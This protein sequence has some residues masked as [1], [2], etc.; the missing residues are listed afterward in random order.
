MANEYISLA[1]FKAEYDLVNTSDDTELAGIL[2]SG[3]RLVDS[4]CLRY[5]YVTQ[6][7]RKFDQDPFTPFYLNIID[8][9]FSLTSVVNGDGSTIPLAKIIVYPLRRTP[10][11]P[12]GWLE[13]AA[14][15]RFVSDG[16]GGRQCLLVDGKW[17]YCDGEAR[18]EAIKRATLQ[19]SHWLYKHPDAIAKVAGPTKV[20][21]EEIV[22]MIP[23]AVLVILDP[24]I[25]EWHGAHDR[26]R[27]SQQLWPR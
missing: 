16:L 19:L 9:L 13:L 12:I 10:S 2:T 4:I 11:I 15:E 20:G 17:G 8:D 3:S 27:Q 23:S 24:Y 14:G 18:P 22:T 6:E 7:V 25:R 5:F 21:A 1:E 26:W